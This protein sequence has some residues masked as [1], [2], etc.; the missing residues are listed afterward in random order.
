M[1]SKSMMG[2]LNFKR[3]KKVPNCIFFLFSLIVLFN[4]KLNAIMSSYGINFLISNMLANQANVRFPKHLTNQTTLHTHLPLWFLN[5]SSLGTSNFSFCSIVE[6]NFH[7]TIFMLPYGPT[8]S[9][10]QIN[11]VAHV[12]WKVQFNCH[13]IFCFFFITIVIFSPLSSTMRL[14]GSIL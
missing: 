12:S 2:L 9:S 14:I 10:T 6:Q 4:L 3:W 11:F 1:F 8:T 7:W 13:S 5:P